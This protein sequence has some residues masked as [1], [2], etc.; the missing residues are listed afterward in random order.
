[1]GP[2]H[3]YLVRQDPVTLVDTGLHTSDSR[4]AL[5]DGL[6]AAGVELKDIRR[7]LLT[8]A[9]MD[10]YGQ[11]G[12]VQE[13]SG[14]EVFMHP[15]EVGKAEVPEWWLDGRGQALAAAG[16]PDETEKLMDHYWRLGRKMAVELGQWQP[17]ADGQK[18]GF[19]S[20]ELE[21][22]HL[23]GHALGHTGF[24]NA[25]HGLLIGGDHLLEGVT[26]NPIMEPL[27]PGH[28]AAVPHAP[29][30][31]L[32]LGQFL[33]ALERVAGLPVKRVM[34]G[35]G[36]IIMDHRAVAQTYMAKHERRLGLLAQRIAEGGTAFAITREIYPRVRE[37]DIFLALSEVLAHLD[38]LVVR[39]QAAVEPGAGGGADTY[40]AVA[41]D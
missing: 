28:P 8:H 7:V 10:H 29:H 41:V 6:R 31:A 19:A 33:S 26:P 3:V 40:S 17:L 1:M 14:A 37:F 38:L 35:H 18:F 9:H 21:A 36:P 23:P 39:G 15:D 22:V 2:V 4:A 13:V 5:L 12:W 24:W 20:F 11:A 16:V 32:T 25:D 34:P 27:R 30:R